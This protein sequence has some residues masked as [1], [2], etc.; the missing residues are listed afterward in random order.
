MFEEDHAPVTLSEIYH[1]AASCQ[2]TVELARERS[3]I[4]ETFL[5][6]E[7]HTARWTVVGLLAGGGSRFESGRASQPGAHG[8]V[9]CLNER[10]N[11]RL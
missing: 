6:L 5:P 1:Q 9:E 7:N 4:F 11:P 10:G 2:R 3:R 8:V